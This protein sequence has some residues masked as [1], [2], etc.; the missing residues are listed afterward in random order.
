MHFGIVI[1]VRKKGQIDVVFDATNEDGRTVEP[2]GNLSLNTVDVDAGTAFIKATVGSILDG[3]AD[4]DGT[5]VVSGKVW[6][7]ASNDIGTLANAITKYQKS[8][9]TVPTVAHQ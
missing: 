2:I 7:F 9:K 4:P 5:N 6:L 1:T 3:N 8:L